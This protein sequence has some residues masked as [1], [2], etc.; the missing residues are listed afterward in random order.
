MLIRRLKEVVF[1]FFRSMIEKLSS[2]YGIVAFAIEITIV[3]A[4][5]LFFCMNE[6]VSDSSIQRE[7]LREA[8]HNEIVELDVENGNVVWLKESIEKETAIE[9]ALKE[10]KWFNG[11]V[12]AKRQDYK[13]G[14]TTGIS[15]AF[16]Y[17]VDVYY[18]EESGKKAIFVVKEG[19]KV[20]QTYQKI[21]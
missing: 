3:G 7:H 9:V 8:V 17:K 14:F 11:E 6:P 2:F 4:I 18:V 20:K 16:R 13:A 5:V 10:A 15:P 12:E 21:N 1:R 19:T